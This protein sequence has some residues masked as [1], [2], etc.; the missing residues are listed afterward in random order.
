M[1]RALISCALLIGCSASTSPIDSGASDLAVDGA[2]SKDAARDRFV[3]QRHA[4][5]MS[6]V[7][8][9]VF[10]RAV[11][12]LK[13]LVKRSAVLGRGAGYS[14]PNAAR[15]QSL[16]RALRGLLDCTLDSQVELKASE[17][18][19]SLLTQPDGREFWLLSTK[20]AP[21]GLQIVVLNPRAKR[22]MLIEAP[23]PR[24]D[25]ETELQAAE[26]FLRLDARAL[27]ISGAHRCASVDASPCSGTTTVCSASGSAPYRKSDAA[28]AVDTLFHRAH[29]TLSDTELKLTVLAMHGF[30]HRVGMPEL[31]ISDGTSAVAPATARINRLAALLRAK[32]VGVGNCNEANG[33]GSLCGT[34]DVQGRHLNRSTAACSAAAP[35]ASGRFLHIEQ[36]LSRR[37]DSADLIDVLSKL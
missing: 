18:S 32:K 22:Q 31:I 8:S 20:L 26:L 6:C 14:P 12:D 37:R 24:S 36:S 9:S 28:H 16:D 2:I 5:S 19:L 4:D 10:T 15:L 21:S 3:D 11:G 35:S 29:K 7:P 27:L 17:S 23:H 33:Y 25:L 13:D 30:G 34:Q 1:R